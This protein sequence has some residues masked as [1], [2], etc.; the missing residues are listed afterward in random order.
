MK[1]IKEHGFMY[2]W[3]NV[4]MYHYARYA[5]IVLTAI[6]LIVFLT[7]DALTHRA[8][9]DLGIVIATGYTGFGEA[10]LQPLKELAEQ[11]VGD[12]D[13]DGIVNIDLYVIDLADAD[14]INQYNRLEL[15]LSK[16]E[17]EYL[18]ILLDDLRSRTHGERG[19][20]DGLVKFGFDPPEDEWYRIY[21]G[22]SPVVQTFPRASSTYNSYRFTNIEYA[23]L[24]TWKANGSLGEKR[25]DAAVRLLNAIM[26]MDVSG[27]GN[28]NISTK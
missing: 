28:D 19:D 7:I 12:I 10:Q 2:W 21:I 25:A 20:F 14:G 22:D 5:L 15:V 6:A 26:G 23:S 1:T 8:K 18:L 3:H 16:S 17:D 13:G 24:Q 9:L 27:A 11:V 4:F